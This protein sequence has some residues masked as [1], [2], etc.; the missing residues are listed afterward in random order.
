MKTACYKFIIRK[1]STH[2]KI[3]EGKSFLFVV[4]EKLTPANFSIS[5]H[6]RLGH[7]SLSIQ[8][9]LFRRRIPP[10][11]SG[12]FPQHH[13]DLMTLQK[14]VPIWIVLIKHF[15]DILTQFVL[16]DASAICLLVS[17]EG[18]EVHFCFSE[19]LSVVVFGREAES[20]RIIYFNI[21]FEYQIP[22]L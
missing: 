13:P 22:N 12:Q 11:P 20:H 14:I 9:Q 19:A 2:Q 5:I 21:T 6:I 8:I 17:G 18:F 1:Y 15:I 16:T 4:V 3:K 7:K 10:S